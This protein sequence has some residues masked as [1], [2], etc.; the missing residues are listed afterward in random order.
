MRG[1]KALLD[2]SGRKALVTGGHGHIA[3]VVV[4]T[5]IE[6]GAAVAIT[7]HDAIRLRDRLKEWRLPRVELFPCDLTDDAQIR[8]MV[9]DVIEWRVSGLDII[10]HC[11]ALTGQ[12]DVGIRKGWVSPFQTQSAT[13]MRYS[14]DVQV[15]SL[16]QICQQAEEALKKS[17]HGS[18]IVLGSIYGVVAPRRELYVGLD[19]TAPIGYSAT[20]G[21]VH[22]FLRHLAREWGPKG[23]RVNGLTPGGL[24]RGQSQEFIDRYESMTP[25][26]RMG[27]EQDL[28]G[29][30]AFLASDMSDYMTGSNLIIDGGFCA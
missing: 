29:A 18:V 1:I 8:T 23:I 12:N 20:K 25:L 9:Q 21:A 28:A 15:V 26:G 10:V 17:G 5:L 6:L 19:F 24:L 13:A 27:T 16:L 11:A 3:R 14:F 2:L 7:D 30:I 22:Q 4:E